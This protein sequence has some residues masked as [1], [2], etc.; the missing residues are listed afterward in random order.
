MD[1]SEMQA[2]M[3]LGK[4]TRI[5]DKAFI[6]F[7][8]KELFLHGYEILNGIFQS[9][10]IVCDNSVENKLMELNSDYEVVPE[11]LNVGPLGGIY[12]GMQNLSSDYVFVSGCDMPFLSRSVIEFLCNEIG[13]DGVIPLGGGGRPEPL[14]AIYRREKI[15][16]L[17]K[18][19]LKGGRATNLIGK[20]NLKIVPADKIREYDPGLMTFRNINTKEDVK[21]IV[22]NITP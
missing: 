20:M 13:K 5:E 1:P 2:L 6:K 9:V 17:G 15:L 10:L 16:E 4:S 12:V 8:G 18:L 7:K 19:C 11:S 22:H 21:S 14:H 3:L